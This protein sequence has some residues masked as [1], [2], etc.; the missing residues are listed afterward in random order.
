M[1]I[2]YSYVNDSGERS[3]TV[4]LPDSTVHTVNHTHP[5]FISA[6]QALRANDV[7]GVYA[8][9]DIDK[10][11]NEAL[12]KLSGKFKY[13]KR[14]VT[15]DGQPISSNLSNAIIS[16]ISEKGDASP[17]IK[18]AM[19]LEQN[20]SFRSRTQLFSWVERHGLTLDEDGDLIAYKGVQV[21]DGDQYLSIN[22]GDGV[23]D[24]VAYENSALPNYVGA[25][26]L[27]PRN[28][29][30]DNPDSLCSFGL[31]AGTFE[32]A[33]NF[34][35]GATLTVKINPAD[36]VSVPKDGHKIRCSEYVV[37]S[38]AETEWV[39]STVWDGN[40]SYEDDLDI[41]WCPEC[42]EWLDE[43]ECSD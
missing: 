23:V 34:G 5:N 20:P 13:E 9:L 15:Y 27:V 16:T 30:D 17:F 21:S 36:V 42:D 3:L 29:V 7:A 12:G 8:A 6:L 38:T 2:R 14:A 40:P 24:G 39:R 4:V 41:D 35:R 26:V 28:R 10:V 33:S 18:F 19:K 25:T 31:H 43:C 32:Y 1:S 11:Y 37:V 22:T